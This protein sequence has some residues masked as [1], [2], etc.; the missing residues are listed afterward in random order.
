VISGGSK[1][2]RAATRRARSS[3]ET[4]SGATGSPMTRLMRDHT[5]RNGQLMARPY[6]R[7]KKL[8]G[9][10]DAHAVAG[11]LGREA[12]GVGDCTALDAWANRTSLA[13]SVKH[14]HPR[15]HRKR[16]HA[17]SEL[18]SS[19]R[20]QGEKAIAPRKRR[21]GRSIQ[22]ACS[23]RRPAFRSCPCSLGCPL[24]SAP[25]M[26]P[27][28]RRSFCSPPSPPWRRRSAYIGDCSASSAGCRGSSPAARRAAVCAPPTLALRPTCGATGFTFHS[29]RPRHH[30]SRARR[31]HVQGRSLFLSLS[32]RRKRGGGG[33][34]QG[35]RCPDRLA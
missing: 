2:P 26:H 23:V 34:R 6:L 30:S 28:R 14:C 7:L 4:F 1:P 18:S 5:R 22:A 35:A 17:H 32:R 25:R 13:R 12:A 8:E 31:A 16:R 10:G 9:A 19:I 3:A 15:S 20:C 29:R 27:G 21:R 24:L 11:P 33:D